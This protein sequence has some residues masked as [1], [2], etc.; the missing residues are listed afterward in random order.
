MRLSL[1]EQRYCRSVGSSSFEFVRRNDDGRGHLV[2]VFEIQQAD[3]LRGAAG[4]A[5][6]LVSMRMILPNWL[7]TISSE[8]SLTS[9]IDAVLPTLGVAFR[10][11]TPCAPRAVRRYSSTSVRLP[12]PFSV[13][14]RMSDCVTQSFSSSSLS[15]FHASSKA[16][17]AALLFGLQLL[18]FGSAV[19]PC[20]RVPSAVH[21]WRPHRPCATR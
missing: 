1:A 16:F 20:L 7:M 15:A 6:G 4:G 17:S 10:L 2:V 21:L 8:V 18:V 11:F 12:K 14:V 13:T 9:R 19:A 5:N 3:A